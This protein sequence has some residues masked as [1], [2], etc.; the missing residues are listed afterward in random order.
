MPTVPPSPDDV[1]WLTRLGAPYVATALA[2]L[3]SALIGLLTWMATRIVARVDALEAALHGRATQPELDAAIA[4]LAA[5]DAR[6]SKELGD[7]RVHVEHAA[8]TKEELE[9]RLASMLSD[10]RVIE[11]RLY[12][13][14]GRQSRHP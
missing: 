7:L 3:L 5:V 10:L 14:V 1:D 6:I 2:G 11:S 12:D 4:A 8:V 13:V 9:R